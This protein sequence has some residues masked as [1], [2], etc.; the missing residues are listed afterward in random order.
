MSQAPTAVQWQES[1]VAEPGQPS[2]VDT[3]KSELTKIRT[4]RSAFWSYIAAVV[5]VVGLGELICSL[6]PSTS[7][8]Y[9]PYDYYNIS[10]GTWGLG[11]LAFM[12]LGVMAVTNEYATGLLGNTYLA[13]P[14]R[15]RV[16]AAKLISFSALTIIIAEIM[17]FVQWAIAYTILDARHFSPFPGGGMFG[18]PNILRAVIGTGVYATLVGLMG[19]GLGTILRHTAGSIVAAVA[20]LLVLPGLT[21]LLPQNIWHTI[22]EFWPTEVGSNFANVHWP[23]YELSP[24]LGLLDM[25]IF[26]AVLLGIGGWLMNRRDT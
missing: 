20:I 6:V 18:A 26:V 17:A 4:L 22:L 15:L 7:S 19:M 12:V 21:H 3:V 13:T 2:L 14:R 5:I 8:S 23:Y 16:L 10:T 1:S 11:Q 24:W 9:G 25:V